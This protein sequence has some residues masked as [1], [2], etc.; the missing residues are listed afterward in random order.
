MFVFGGSENREDA[1]VLPNRGRG[2]TEPTLERNFDNLSFKLTGGETFVKLNALDLSKDS[3]VEILHTVQ[4]GMV[5]YCFIIA[6][7]NFLNQDHIVALTK[8]FRNYN[9]KALHRN[10]TS[11]LKSFRSFLGR[12]YKI[13]VQLLPSL[14]QKAC[15]DNPALFSDG[16][17]FQAMFECFDNLGSLA[18]LCYM[19][20]IDN[21]KQYKDLL[22]FTVSETILA[23]DKLQHTILPAQN[24]RRV[25]AEANTALAK[26]KFSSL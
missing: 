19:E 13:L 16:A 10:L 11:S 20:K 22:E 26:M 2:N 6:Y 3:P 21:F 9:S 4:L 24:R 5:K 12:D 8:L 18:S 14:L 7:G 15:L 1:V 23:M 25:N 17:S